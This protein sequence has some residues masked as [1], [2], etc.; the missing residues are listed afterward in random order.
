[1]ESFCGDEGIHMCLKKTFIMK[2]GERMCVSMLETLDHF[3]SGCTIMAPVCIVP[4]L[5]YRHSRN[6][7]FCTIRQVGYPSVLMPTHSI[8]GR[9]PRG[10]RWSQWHIG[11]GNPRNF[12][13]M[14]KVHKIL[15]ASG[16]VSK[17]I[18]VSP[19]DLGLSQSL[20]HTMK[21]YT[22]LETPSIIRRCF[23]GSCQEPTTGHDY[24]SST[25]FS[26]VGRIA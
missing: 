25:N 3:T 21:K 24:Q 8:W 17:P 13:R 15:L 4:N 12:L 10:R 5:A 20:P 1:M 16:I 23:S 6:A 18:M 19:G 14:V 9:K 26:Q 7:I 2:D 22:I 11:S